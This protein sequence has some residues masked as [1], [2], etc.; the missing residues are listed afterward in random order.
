MNSSIKSV[1]ILRGSQSSMYGSGAIGSTGSGY[2]GGGTAEGDTLL[3]IENVY[4][5]Q[6]NDTFVGNEDANTLLGYGG[7]DIL[8]GNQGNDNLQ[9]GDGQDELYGGLGNDSLCGGAGND[10][11][12]FDTV[13][14]QGGNI[15]TIVDFSIDEDTLTLS[16]SVF[17]S[18]VSDDGTLLTENF[19][20]SLTGTAS[21]ENDYLLYNTASGSLLYDADGS[22]SGVAVEFAKLTTKPGI[23][24]ND[25]VIA[26]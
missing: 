25:F 5:T 18:L 3:S 1:E 10:A 15:D 14:D 22:G 6:F 24:A 16:K 2:G 9:G 21:D 11:F 7:D 26:A 17:T 13:L 12:V 4:G 20:A 23:T 19:H 8:S